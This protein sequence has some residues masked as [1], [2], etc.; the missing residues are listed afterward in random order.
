MFNPCQSEALTFAVYNLHGQRSTHLEDKHLRRR[1]SDVQSSKMR[2]TGPHSLETGRN[3]SRQPNSG[4]LKYGA[5]PSINSTFDVTHVSLSENRDKVCTTVWCG[6]T[7]C[8]RIA[9]NQQFIHESS[10]RGHGC[11]MYKLLIH[12]S[13]A[14]VLHKS[15]PSTHAPF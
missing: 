13:N 7:S 6:G 5:M 12:M 9:T 11:L 1:S 14:I 8:H 3:I 15:R 4:M 10:V 2:S